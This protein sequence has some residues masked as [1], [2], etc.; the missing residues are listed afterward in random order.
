MAVVV[1][2]LLATQREKARRESG[3]VRKRGKYL[4]EGGARCRR[5]DQEREKE[6]A[7]GKLLTD[8]CTADRRTKHWPSPPSSTAG[9]DDVKSP[10]S[11]SLELTFAPSVRSSRCYVQS[12]VVKRAEP[13]W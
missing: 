2:V 11:S 9:L 6:D 5:P 13:L 12:K 10:R 4:E 7:E 3:R 8:V 1:K